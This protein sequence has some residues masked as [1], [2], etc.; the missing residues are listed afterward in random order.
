MFDEDHFS[1]TSLVAAAG[2]QTADHARLLKNGLKNRK[3]YA[4]NCEKN[5][6]SNYTIFK[7]CVSQLLP[8]LCKKEKTYFGLN[9]ILLQFL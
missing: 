1:Y 7:N 3:K 9:Q 4:Q 8:N 5:A 6:H 2:C